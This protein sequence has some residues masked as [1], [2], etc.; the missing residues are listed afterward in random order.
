MFQ[1]LRDCDSDICRG[2]DHEFPTAGSQVDIFCF[3][4]ISVYFQ[5]TYAIYLIILLFFT[6]DKTNMNYNICDAI[7]QMSIYFRYQY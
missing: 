4:L 5:R 7:K 1:V 3:V 2:G 6:N